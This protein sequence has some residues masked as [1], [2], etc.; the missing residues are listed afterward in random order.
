VAEPGAGRGVVEDLDDLRAEAASELPVAA[1]GVLAG[2]PALLVRR[3]TE[4]EVGLPE[5]SVMGDD[6]VARGENIRQA[7]LHGGI[8]LDGAANAETRTCH[9]GPRVSD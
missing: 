3:G 5:Q 8:D 7:G 1:E 4:R 6:A 2:D 9:G